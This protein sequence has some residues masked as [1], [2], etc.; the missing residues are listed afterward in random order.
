MKAYTMVNMYMKGIQA[1]IQAAHAQSQLIL[2]AFTINHNTTFRDQIIEW[3]KNP[4][5]ILKNGGDWRAMNNFLNLCHNQSD[6]VY[7]EFYESGLGNNVLTA[8]T[9]IL[10]D[11]KELCMYGVTGNQS[12]LNQFT[13]P[14][15]KE[16]ILQVNKC[17]SAS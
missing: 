1:G 12:R 4:V 7:S 17:R 8:I 5:M 14:V 2:D 15:T 10:P 16:L 9:V 11:V 3:S 13:N 6:F